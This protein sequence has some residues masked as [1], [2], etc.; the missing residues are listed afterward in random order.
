MNNKQN[1]MCLWGNTPLS[2]GAQWLVLTAGVAEEK[3]VIKTHVAPAVWG[4]E[5]LKQHLGRQGSKWDCIFQPYLE[6]CPP[7]TLFSFFQLAETSLLPS[8]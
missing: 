3:D 8:M 1:G 2:L 4:D 7:E 6:G 5:G